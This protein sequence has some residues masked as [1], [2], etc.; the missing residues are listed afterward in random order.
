MVQVNTTNYFRQLI[1]T[2]EIDQL[3]ENIAN[4]TGCFSTHNHIF[5]H[6]DFKKLT[7]MGNKIIPYLFHIITHHGGSWTIFLLLGQ[8]TNENP[9]PKDE[10]SKFS[11]VMTSWLQWYIDSSYV[12][13]DVYFNLVSE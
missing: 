2:D 7:V 4:D 3:L 13:H 9:V 6:S 11:V 1:I 10:W 12:N 8:I 5:K